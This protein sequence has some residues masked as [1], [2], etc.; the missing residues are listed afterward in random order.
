MEGGTGVT[1]FEKKVTPAKNSIQKSVQE[2][3]DYGVFGFLFAETERH[4]FYELISRY[5]ADG[6]FVDER[7]FGTLCVYLGRG[8]YA[9]VVE[10]YAV[11]FD[12]SETAV[13]TD[14]VGNERLVGI[15]ARYAAADDVHAAA[16][17]CERYSETRYRAFGARSEY[18]FLDD[19]PRVFVKGGGHGAVGVGYAAELSRFHIQRRTILD[20]RAGD[21][22]KR[23]FAFRVAFGVV[24]LD[25]A[26]AAAFFEVEGMHAVVTAFAAGVVV[27]TAARDYSHFRALADIEIVVNGVEQTA[28]GENDGDMHAFVFNARLDENVDAFLAVGAGEYF[29]VAVGGAGK[30]F[31]VLADI[32]R[33]FGYAVKLGDLK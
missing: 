4:Q 18:F 8:E 1:F 19:K 27:Y 9:R 26:H 12:V 25:V 33:A 29:H 31:A 15:V 7:G 14:Y 30:A 22:V 5:L 24:P 10:Q 28:F 32:V 13:F 2:T 23:L 17:A 11:A 3:F 21:G 20:K 6:G 16:F